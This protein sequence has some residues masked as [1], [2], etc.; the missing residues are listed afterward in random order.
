MTYSPKNLTEQI[1][2]LDFVQ[3]A[4]HWEKYGKERIYVNLVKIS[5]TTGKITKGSGRK[6]YVDLTNDGVLCCSHYHYDLGFGAYAN[7]NT[8]SYH[9]N[10]K[11]RQQLETILNDLDLGMNFECGEI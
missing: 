11:S 8:Y 9:E 1:N 10:N 6:M 3:S 5:R 4:N 2:N 7:R